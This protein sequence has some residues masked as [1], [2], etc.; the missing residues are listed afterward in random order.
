M[1]RA[2]A[3]CLA[4]GA[5]TALAEPRVE[6]FTDHDHPVRHAGAFAQVTV[7]RIDGLVQVQDRLS[8]GL[9]ADATEAARL[10]A[11]RLDAEPDLNDQ[12]MQAGQGLALAHLQYRLDRYPAIVLDG[13][14]VIYGVTDLALARRLYE[15]RP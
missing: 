2:L 4:L 13:E 8:A 14:Y 9:P 10:A 11:E 3:L 7:Y 15:E 5:G 1:H 12:L 6:V